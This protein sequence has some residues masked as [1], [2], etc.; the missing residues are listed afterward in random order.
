MGCESEATVISRWHRG[1]ESACQCWG[2]GFDIWVGKIPWS[3]K[4]QPTP[5]FLP[6]KSHRQKSLAGYSPWGGKESNRME[7]A[8]VIST[9]K[10]FLTPWPLYLLVS[11]WGHLPQAP[12]HSQ[13]LAQTFPLRKAVINHLTQQPP[14]YSK[15]Y[16]GT[17]QIWLL[18]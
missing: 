6:G 13:I 5:E 17:I 16:L 2:H 1:K 14:N 9:L 10:G 4:W 3:R 18:W 7:H 8:S 12:S 15:N 11:A